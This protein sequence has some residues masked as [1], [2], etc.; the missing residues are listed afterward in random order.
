MDKGYEVYC[1]ADPS[2]YDSPMAVPSSAGDFEEAR[3]PVLDG[4]KRVELDDWLVYAPLDAKIPPQGWKIHASACID[5]A[6]KVLSTVWDYLVPRGI[7]FKFIRNRELLFLR[8][9]KYADRGG[10][11]KFVTIYPRDDAEFELI[12]S[13]LG[14]LLDGEPGPYILSDL[15]YGNGPLYVRYG[16]FADLYCIGPSGE[17]EPAIADPTGELVPD[18]RG[19]TFHVPE[20]LTLPTCLAPQLEARNSTTVE[21]I[22]YKIERALHFSNGG[23]LYVGKDERSGEQVVLKEARPHA[24]LAYDGAD[25]VARLNRE[26]EMLE[27]LAG[28][29]L[30]PAVR[31]HFTLG[32]HEF[33]V[34]E[35]IEGEQLNHLLVDKYPLI[36]HEPDDAAIAQ[37]AGWVLETLGRVEAAIDACHERGVVIGDLHPANIL[38]RPDGRIVLIDLEVASDVSEARPQTMA[39]PGF[40]APHGVTGFDLDRYAL[41]ALRLYL[42]LPLPTLIA[43]DTSKARAFAAEIADLFPVPGEFLAEAVAVIERLRGTDE[44]ESA[45]AAGAVRRLDPDPAQWPSTRDSIATAILASA[46]PERDDRLFPG[47]VKQ[48]ETS[49]LNL[50]Y[51]AAGV[52]YALQATG[53]G[54]H[55]EH[56]EWLARHAASP[57]PGTRLGFY[58]GLHGVAYALERLGRRSEALAVLELCLETLDGRWDALGSSLYAGLAGVGLNLQ[59]FAAVTGDSALRDATREV[60]DALADRL[61][62][63]ESVPTES[64]GKH[65]YAGLLRGSSGLALFFLRL[66]EETED[67]ALLDLAATAIRQ[68]LRRCMV[69]EDGVMHV[70]EGWRTMPYLADGSIGIGVVLDD[71]L[72]HRE[73]EELAAARE[74]IRRAATAHFYA[75]SGL[76]W[77]RAGMIL[78]LSRDHEPGTA[79]RD[80]IVARHVRNLSWHALT[81]EGHLAFPGEELLRLSMDLA[82]GSAGVLLALAAAFEEDEQPVSL[83]FLESNRVN[84]ARS[85]SGLLLTAEGR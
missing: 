28:A 31:D 16:G 35:F 45:P 56:E 14:E 37:Y 4:W 85:Q 73:D 24:G 79:H 7:P 39:D 40:A 64:G 1:H 76:F 65:P 43:F 48:F 59:H 78:Y 18:Q 63:V 33:V 47:D 69:H 67:A 17:L 38:V 72:A 52:L 3:R 27:R 51:G 49:G 20:W 68:D 12:L 34:M 25:A 11:G 9:V 19:A 61:G 82:T 30:V 83:P 74:G 8:N 2:F 50:A 71:Y 62:D 42:F 81:Y 10:S 57:Q 26:R 55:P 6:A 46:T 70:N 44:T 41:A 75:E 77:G 36:D 21:E 5:N 58:D 32:E 53:C 54:Q 13:E 66:H 84:E 22:P 60:A 29:E 23:G 15:R 80:S